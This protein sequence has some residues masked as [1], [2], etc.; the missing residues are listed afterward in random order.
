MEDGSP[1][2]NSYGFP[3]SFY[4]DI[5]LPL[6]WFSL[7]FIVSKVSRPVKIIAICVHADGRKTLLL[8]NTAS[9]PSIGAAAQRCLYNILEAYDSENNCRVKSSWASTCFCL[10]DSWQLPRWWASCQNTEGE[11]KLRHIKLLGCILAFSDIALKCCLLAPHR[12]L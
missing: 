3:S 8:S 7:K 10:S 2:M 4:S 5:F 6:R 11:I 12:S 1:Y 9:V